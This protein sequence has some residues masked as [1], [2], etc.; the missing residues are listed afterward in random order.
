MPQMG[1]WPGL[2]LDDLGVHPTG[3]VDDAVAV[4]VVLGEAAGA[5][6]SMSISP[7]ATGASGIE[8]RVRGP[9]AAQ[10]RPRD[11]GARDEDHP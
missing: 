9:V 7:V 11:A 6:A 5:G 2:V 8:M 1:H 4:E 10:E 3:L